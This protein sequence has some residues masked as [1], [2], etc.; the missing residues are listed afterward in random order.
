MDTPTIQSPEHDLGPAPRYRVAMWFTLAAVLVLTG[1][2]V[3]VL[4]FYDPGL[5]IDELPDRTFPDAA[6]EVCARAVSE[7]SALPLANESDSADDRAETLATSNLIFARMV[8]ELHPLVADAQTLYLEDTEK[9]FTKE[10]S[11]G[12]A[13]GIGDW[14][15]DWGTYL[16]DREEYVER[17]RVDDDARFLE[18]AKGSDTKGITRAINSFAQVNA[19]MSCVTPGDVS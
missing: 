3:Y 6:E 12:Y 17:L 11:Q 15:D 2:W 13:K 7:F 8:D 10:E 19:M 18:T 16:E 5:L 1:S 14:V 9:R 4:F